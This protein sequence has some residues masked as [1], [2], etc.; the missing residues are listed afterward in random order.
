[1]LGE[2]T[3]VK[4]INKYLTTAQAKGI[5][6]V[7]QYH[8]DVKDGK[9]KYNPNPYKKRSLE[10]FNKRDVCPEQMLFK[11]KELGKKLGRAP[12]MADFKR[13]YGH[14]AEPSKT[15]FGS[16]REAVIKAGFEPLPPG[17]IKGDR[18]QYEDDYMIKQM[19]DFF[20]KY[21]RTPRTSDFDSH[22]DGLP[23][24]S[25]I[26]YRFGGLTKARAIAKIPNTQYVGSGVWIEVSK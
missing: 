21:G 8:Q 25:T 10:D 26:N 6:A 1:M 5:E 11:I 2:A 4:L 12:S 16:Y 19:Q 15:H 23:G 7:K 24:I 13:E 20:T 22:T 14:S 9:R 17:S 3:R 18:V